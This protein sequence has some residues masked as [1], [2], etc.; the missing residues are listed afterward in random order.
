MCT[1]ERLIGFGGFEEVFLDDDPGI[2]F[3]DRFGRRDFLS[4]LDSFFCVVSDVVSPAL[5]TEQN[6]NVKRAATVNTCIESFPIE[7]EPFKMML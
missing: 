4:K 2:C 1:G 5:E 3:G 7:D 6:V